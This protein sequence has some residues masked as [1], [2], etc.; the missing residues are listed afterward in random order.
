M[1]KKNLFLTLFI[2]LLA[3]GCAAKKVE[4][5]QTGFLRDY[6]QLKEDDR[7][8]GVLIYRN[9]SVDLTQ[10]YT[11]VMIAPVVIMLDQSEG[12][13]ELSQEDTSKLANFFY[14][15]LHEKL[16]GHYEIAMEPGEGVLLLRSALTNLLANRRY[17]NIH[18]S[19]TLMGAGIGGASIEAELVDS[20]TNERVLA[21]TDARKG[22]RLN[23]KKPGELLPTYTDGLTKWGHTESVLEY[24]AQALVD[25]LEDLKNR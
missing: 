16:Q 14:G 11:K 8:E 13:K 7:Q 20:L 2:C 10:E 17:L 6:A 3:G 9:E 18:W 4:L 19:T 24:W 25:N 15:K 23:L 12:K 21:F 22:D 1:T 5:T